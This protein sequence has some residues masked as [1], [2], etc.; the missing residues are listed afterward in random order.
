MSIRTEQAAALFAEGFNCAQ[1]VLGAFCEKYGVD[2]DSALKM[3]SGLG[4]GF[5]MGE[6]CGAASGAAL[7]IGLKYGMGTAGDAQAKANGN[8]KTAEFMKLFRAGHGSLLCRELLGLDLS[9]N[10]QRE[11]AQSRNLFKTACPNLV[12][13][14]V[15]LLE[16][17]G[18]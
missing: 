14:A 18:Y 4:S 17:L 6:I 2:K 3:S 15:S 10:E 13:S 8:R 16:E 12:L 11:Q 5:R 9:I 1:S 7:V